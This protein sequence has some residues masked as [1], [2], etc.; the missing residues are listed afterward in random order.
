MVTEMRR[1]NTVL[2]SRSGLEVGKSDADSA[3]TRAHAIID[4]ERRTGSLVVCTV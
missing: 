3:Q 1:T 4:L 2:G